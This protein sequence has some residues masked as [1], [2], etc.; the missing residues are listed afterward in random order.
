MLIAGFLIYGVGAT[1][2]MAFD[3]RMYVRRWRLNS[4]GLR[5]SFVTGLRDIHCRRH[6]TSAWEVWREEAPWM[7]LYFSVGVWTSLAMVLL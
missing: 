5:L 2:T 7:T 1:L 4:A 6:A 3:V